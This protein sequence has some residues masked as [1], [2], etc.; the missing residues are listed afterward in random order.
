MLFFIFKKHIPTV[1]TQQKRLLSVFLAKYESVECASCFY[2]AHLALFTFICYT[3][4]TCTYDLYY[5]V[6][7]V[8][9]QIFQL[10]CYCKI[11]ECVKTSVSD[12]WH[13]DTDQDPDTRIRTT[14][15][16]ILL[17]SSRCQQK[18]SLSPLSAVDSLQVLRPN[19]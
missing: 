11:R 6:Q 17:F 15:L 16:R 2:A 10:V 12:P 9:L 1:F 3:H 7:S 13:F 5:Y 8:S 18:I 14:G 19:L 4:T